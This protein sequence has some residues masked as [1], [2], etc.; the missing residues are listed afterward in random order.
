[1]GN[2]SHSISVIIPAYNS[3]AYLTEAIES[4][5][6]QTFPG[7]ELIVVDDGSTDGT[8]TVAH[9]FSDPRVKYHYQP[10]RGPSA[11]R[12][13]GIRLSV[14]EFLCFLDADDLLEPA[15][16]EKQLDYLLA[17][18]DSEIVFCDWL[19]VDVAGKV[20]QGFSY[21]GEGNLFDALLQSN[22]F[23]IHAPLVRR[24]VLDRVGFFDESL[25]AME[26]WD[27]WLR[28]AENDVLFGRIDQ[29]LV[30]YRLTAGSNSSNPKRVADA[31]FQVLD[32][33]FS[34]RSPSSETTL[35]KE[36]IYAAAHIRIAMN[37]FE[38]GEELQ[39]RYHLHRAGELGTDVG[40]DTNLL[41][42]Q[43]FKLA[44][45]KSEREA[46]EFLQCVLQHMEDEGMTKPEKAEALSKYHALLA[47]ARLNRGDFRQSLV[48][49]LAAVRENPWWLLRPS[50]RSAIV[51]FL[52]RRRL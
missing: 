26:D 8:A 11:A 25:M 42:S 2:D 6:A 33:L 19:S 47:A 23:P 31:T 18:P 37:Y 29:P 21:Q 45:R 30:R 15:K 16:L 35:S 7:L 28:V 3:E 22:K 1:M 17:R 36:Q 46:L 5:L 12:N 50:S 48:A 14:G 9:R 4:V 27:L 51:Q 40:A 44:H 41:A 10:N 43:A 39:G 38:Y 52:R 13:R 20:I 49:G 24:R 32:K 34:R